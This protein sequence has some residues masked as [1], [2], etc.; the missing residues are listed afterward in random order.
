MK[1]DRTRLQGVHKVNYQAPVQGKKIQE[2]TSLPQ[3]GV[4]G[5]TRLVFKGNRKK[6]ERFHAS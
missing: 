1:I 6:I 5:V 2:K 3:D 4:R